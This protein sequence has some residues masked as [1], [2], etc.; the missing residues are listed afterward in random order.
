[1]KQSITAIASALL[2]A[3]V[4]APSSRA[5]ELNRLLGQAKDAA[6]NTPADLPGIVALSPAGSRST[7]T[8]R[9]SCRGTAGHRDEAS[10]VANCERSETQTTPIPRCAGAA[11]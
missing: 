10:A 2:F 3:A 4:S 9:R 11:K 7:R 8:Q 5:A 6:L 1:V